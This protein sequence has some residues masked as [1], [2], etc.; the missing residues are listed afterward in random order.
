MH[1]RLL[2]LFMGVLILDPSLAFTTEAEKLFSRPYYQLLEEVAD[3]SPLFENPVAV[4]QAIESKDGQNRIRRLRKRIA[5]ARMLLADDQL[6]SEKKISYLFVRM[7]ASQLIK[8]GEKWVL[9]AQARVDEEE[10]EEKQKE[11]NEKGRGES[12]VVQEEQ[13]RPQEKV[14][15]I[16][17][18]RRDNRF[19]IFDD[20]EFNLFDVIAFPFRLVEMILELLFNILLFPF[21]IISKILF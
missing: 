15:I 9:M 6:Q 7:S 3:A 16:E 20:D 17:R 10:G 2:I 8:T 11:R 14:I 18:K 1:Y 4:R 5:V 19:D 12:Q 13:T 21:K